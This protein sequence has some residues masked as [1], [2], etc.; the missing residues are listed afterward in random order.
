MADD[1]YRT[2]SDHTSRLRLWWM[3]SGEETIMN[4]IND[5]SRLLSPWENSARIG[6]SRTMLMVYGLVSNRGN[7]RVVADLNSGTFEGS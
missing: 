5:P 3:I 1:R 6:L 4:G 7:E 2:I